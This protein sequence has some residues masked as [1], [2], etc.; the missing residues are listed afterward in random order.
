MSKLSEREELKS[1]DPIKLA[2]IDQLYEINK[3]FLS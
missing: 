3:R 2:L 1:F